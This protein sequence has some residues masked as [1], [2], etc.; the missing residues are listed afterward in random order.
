M[1]PTS[2]EY[3]SAIGSCQH[4][5]K[6]LSSK[7]V[8]TFLVCSSDYYNW[9]VLAISKVDPKKLLAILQPVISTSR[10]QSNSRG[11]SEDL[12]HKSRS[13][14]TNNYVIVGEVKYSAEYTLPMLFALPHRPALFN[15]RSTPL[16]PTTY[17]NH[18]SCISACFQKCRFSL[19]SIQFCEISLDG[20]ICKWN[21]PG[22]REPPLGLD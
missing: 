13:F 11:V 10:L 15:P 17:E 16:R 7:T 9:T 22:Y 6:P 1:D 3:R 14:I 18:L 21:Q 20:S 12:R 5:D 2:S 4:D 8:A 19:G